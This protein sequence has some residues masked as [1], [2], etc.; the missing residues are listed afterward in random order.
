[1]AKH[2]EISAKDVCYGTYEVT[3]DSFEEAVELIRQGRFDDYNMTG[4]SGED[5][6]DF[7]LVDSWSDP[8]PVVVPKDCYNKTLEDVM[9]ENDDKEV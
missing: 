9:K 6:W 4:F 8:E 2:F 1:M 7:E 5:P 3:A